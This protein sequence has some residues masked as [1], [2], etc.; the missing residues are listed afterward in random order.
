MLQK[1]MAALHKS[2]RFRAAIISSGRFPVVSAIDRQT[3]LELQVQC[4]DPVTPARE[5]TSFCLSEH[6]TLRPLF[7]LL[8][9]TLHMR[10]LNAAK[11]G[12]LGSYALLV[13]IIAILRQPGA[14]AVSVGQQLLYALRIIGHTDLARYGFSPHLLDPFYKHSSR[15]PAEPDLHGL[16]VGS[17]GPGQL[18]LQD[19]TNLARNLGADARL[20]P[21]VQ[22]TC[23][24]MLAAVTGR[25]I[26]WDHMTE[27]DRRAGAMRLLD[28]LLHADYG[29]FE[30]RR[31][32]LVQ[33][34]GNVGRSRGEGRRGGGA[35]VEAGQDAEEGKE[36]VAKGAAQVEARSWIRR[37]V[38]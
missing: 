18:T 15:S 7:L 37:G 34:R 27:A 35:K 23:R 6:R 38:P 9:H 8:R 36:G 1:S 21:H 10:E 33:E 19:P 26:R 5:Y 4:I 31:A 25:L 28:P 30:R 13:L 32:R 2:K 17:H 24:G 3:G 12:G 20:M 29:P 16:D 14:P 11:T 22:A